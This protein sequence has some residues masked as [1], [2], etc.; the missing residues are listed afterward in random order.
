MTFSERISN[1]LKL[2]FI[3]ALRRMFGKRR[4]GNAVLLICSFYLI[5]AMLGVICLSH[6]VN[7]KEND[8]LA[9]EYQAYISSASTAT[10]ATS[11]EEAAQAFNHIL[12][13]KIEIASV[14]A[15]LMIIWGVLS[16]FA[17]SRVFHATI[18]QDKYVYGLYVTFGSDTRSIRKQIHIEFVLAALIALALSVPTAYLACRAVYVQ[19][20]QAFRPGIAPYLQ[21]LFWLFLVSLIGAAYLSRGITNSTCVALMA[22]QDCSDY[23]SSPRTSRLFGKRMYNGS[24][25]YARLA[26]RRMRRYYIP[27]VLTVSLVAAVF[28]GSM[29]IALEGERAAMRSV[30]EY[31]LAFAHGLSSR[32]L[33]ENYLD[34]LEQ[35]ADV[36]TVAA[37]ANGS[38]EELG[39]HLLL[40]K[41]YY[42]NSEDS[43]SLVD[44]GMYYATD[45]FN[46]LCA[47]SNTKSEIGSDVVLPDKWL[48]Y[49]HAI[50]K[51]YNYEMIPEAGTVV[52][53]YPEEREAEINVSVGDS[54]RLAIPHAGTDGATLTDKL[55]DGGY[56]YLTLTVSDVVVVPGVYYVTLDEA[57]YICPRITEDYLLLSPT[58]YA[59]IA[60]ED[61]VEALSLD[62]IY[63]EDFMFENITYPAVLL[64]P[65]GY[66]G[67]TLTSIMMFTP[68]ERI[69]EQYAMTDP[70]D[71]SNVKY[72]ESDR[73]YLNRTA[74]YTYFYMGP[75]GNYNN[76]SQA[77][78]EVV[79]IRQNAPVDYTEIELTITDQITCPGLDTPCVLLPNDD[80]F[81][82]S[83]SGDM[84][85]LK[86][87][88]NGTLHGVSEEVFAFGTD[89]MTQLPTYIGK[90]LF[91]HTKLEA[92]FF[93]E[94][95][96]QGLTTTYDNESA[97]E[98]SYFEIFSEFELGNSV[99]FVCSLSRACNLGIDRYPAYMAPGQDFVFLSDSLTA[100]TD[101]TTAQVGSYMM[102]DEKLLRGDGGVEFREVGEFAANRLTVSVAD[103]INMGLLTPD[104]DL[105]PIEAGQAALVLAQNSNLALQ[106]GDHVQLAIMQDIALDPND[107]EAA[108]LEGTALLDYL[109]RNEYSYISLQVV[110][111][112][113]GDGEDDVLYLSEEDWMRIRRT[114][115]TYG[116]IDIYLFGDTDLVSLIKTAADIRE[117]IAERQTTSN[118]I[119]LVEQNRLWKTVTTSA[120]NYPAIIR[121]LSVMLILLLPLLWCAPQLVHF[122]KR[123]DEFAAMDAVGKTS[124]QMR[125]MIAAECVLVTLAAGAFVALLCPLMMLGVHLAISTMELPFV[126]SGFDVSAYLFM[127]GFVMV[128][129]V[130]SFLAGYRGVHPSM[131]TEK[132]RKNRKGETV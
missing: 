1:F 97:Y 99:Y 108:S 100:R 18:E 130:I 56:E 116:V 50:E 40:E 39:T 93:K 31:S 86:L 66:K 81:Y 92:G 69:T 30:H 14:H 61:T 11:S 45:A 43:E 19:N 15:F 128:C 104:S 60:G 82:S 62:E 58:D 127:I 17:L 64:L 9:R 37:L 83:Y 94:M 35:I 122:R 84:C 73:F 10:D 124:G 96:A 32:E 6:H 41:S 7:K 106:A 78:N 98:L 4:W 131:R 63:R 123:R 75:I 13:S 101:R 112:V 59:Q 65:E 110:E 125:G 46:I 28:F 105:A 54:I 115:G 25:R 27:L 51:T 126:L 34:E 52:Y 102:I 38:A 8:R 48:P 67:E 91:L 71:A 109:L 29:S 26:V 21:I 114:D 129:A 5:S 120:C 23:I 89:Q 132:K 16:V 33:T 3:P 95:H 42:H 121:I 55:D 2:T 119:T 68:N 20:G 49:E 76:D 85:V 88:E 87:Y 103:G 79:A 53:M 24:L 77:V 44:S 74:R 107:P 12:T 90:R 113:Q 70:L 47:D 117:L 72:L 57:T 22:A 118:H 80:N 36:E 111:V